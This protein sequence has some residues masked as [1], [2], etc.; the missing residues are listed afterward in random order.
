MQF[1]EHPMVRWLTRL[2]LGD[3]LLTTTRVRRWLLAMPGRLV[4]SGRRVRLRLPQH[5][6]WQT[7]FERALARLRAVE[8]PMRL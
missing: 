1:R 7:V 4:R 6:P 5:W 8:I 2:G 3:R